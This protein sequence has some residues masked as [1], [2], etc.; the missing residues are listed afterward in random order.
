MT[1]S[2]ALGIAVDGTF[3]F[4]SDW[5]GGGLERAA[6]STGRALLLATFVVGLGFLSLTHA[7]FAPTRNFG[8]LCAAAL[9]AALLADLLVL[10][11]TLQA[12]GCS[13]PVPGPGEPTRDRL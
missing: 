12:L 10:P 3:H 6:R 1:A 13:P 9:A 7:E 11:A 8:I 4:L 5:K 2:I